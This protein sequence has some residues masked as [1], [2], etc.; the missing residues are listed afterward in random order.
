MTAK[1]LFEM[2]EREAEAAEKWTSEHLV[3][4][5][6]LWKFWAKPIW[7]KSTMCPH[8]TYSFTP[9]GIG[10]AVTISCHCGAK[11]DVTDYSSW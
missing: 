2:N 4:A 1:Y 3:C 8:F 10:E 6:P 7:S 11:R 5:P 9:T